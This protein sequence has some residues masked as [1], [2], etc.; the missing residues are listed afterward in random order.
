MGAIVRALVLVV[1][2]AGSAGA[3]TPAPS[4]ATGTNALLGRVLE[5][6]TNTP[7]AGA[8]VTLTGPFGSATEPRAVPLANI[9]GGPGAA[10]SVSV[11]TTG[12]GYFV[13]RNLP[14]GLFTTAVRAAGYV[15]SDTPPTVIE[16]LDSPRPTEHT[17]RLWRFAAIG[18]RVT[19]ERGE[20]LAGVQVTA[21]TRLGSGAGVQLRPFA[22]ELTDDRG[23]YR[24]AGLP[25]GEYAVGA[26]STASTV[27]EDVAAALD[28]A[29]S[30]RETAFAMSGEL[31]ESLFSRTFGCSTCLNPP[32]EGQH[33]GGFVFARP[34]MTLPPGPD[35]RPLGFTNTYYPGTST[36]AESSA[37]VLRSGESRSSLDLVLRLSRTVHV[38]G[39]VRGPDGPMPHVAL[40]LVPAGGSPGDFSGVELTGRMAA[41][42]DASG[43]FL[44]LGVPPGD[45]T[46]YVTWVRVRSGNERTLW[47]VQPL[48]VGETDLDGLD[49]QLRPGI[50]I[51]GRL[52]FKG[53]DPPLMNGM[54][55]VINI[56]PSGSPSAWRTQQGRAM[57]DG[58]FR[59]PGDPAGRYTLNAFLPP[60][61]E[62]WFWQSTTLDGRPL[63]G[64]MVDLVSDEVTGLVL[65]FG[66]TTNRISGRVTDAAAD[67]DVAVIAFA[68]DSTAWRTGTF[69]SRHTRKVLATSSG[70]FDIAT[71][72]PG[73]YYVAAVDAATAFNWMDGKFLERLI[74]G[75]TRVTLGPEDLRTI[76]LRVSQ[77]AGRTP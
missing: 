26:L 6:G 3:Q 64:E 74:P 8:V 41:V 38:A 40:N 31:V 39:V 71:L 13:V 46:L 51:S 37:I 32:N 69:D 56:R 23:E 19:D 7:V 55:G 20:P 67:M 10:P 76:S 14:S 18:G 45:Y 75:A 63:P 25:P 65:T 68:A 11:M 35:G 48:G 47:V 42:S 27:P 72:A 15:N 52:E 9:T 28:P 1:L 43:K 60:S 49:V 17:I 2:V 77:I 50:A 33:A 34:A 59:L 57:P 30:N 54:A 61:A 5:V 36:P 4:T 53:G 73:D 24:I 70:A 29:P 16:V 66:R 44:F 22:T 62:S 12:D 21:L 58:T